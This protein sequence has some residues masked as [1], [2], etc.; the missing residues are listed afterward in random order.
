MKPKS[1]FTGLLLA[2]LITPAWA[3]AP[4]EQTDVVMNA[5]KAA[6]QSAQTTQTEAEKLKVLLTHS[7]PPVVPSLPPPAAI[8]KKWHPGHY[9]EA[10]EEHRNGV[11][12]DSEQIAK[13]PEITGIKMRVYWSHLE[14]TQGTYNFSKIESFLALAKA[15]NK[16]LIIEL[17]DR[18]FAT[19]LTPNTAP[20]PADMLPTW[21]VPFFEFGGGTAR[22]WE[23]PVMD[24]FIALIQEIAKRYDAHPN[25]QG[26]KTPESAF[27]VDLSPAA[28]AKT[29]WSFIKYETQTKRL[30]V[31]ADAAFKRSIFFSGLNWSSYVP[32]LATFIAGTQTGITHPD[33]TNSA[34]IPVYQE[35]IRLK[36]KVPLL[37]NMETGLLH[38]T[39]T[40][41]AILLK[42]VNTLG[43]QFVAWER[44][45]FGKDPI[46]PRHAASKAGT[47][48]K[49]YV[50]PVIRKHPNI[51][52]DIP[53]PSNLTYAR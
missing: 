24:R 31:A 32:A 5:A 20:I 52:R 45:F 9:L 35:E 16:M 34:A 36:G 43:A 30:I 3:L 29:G 26:L 28:V 42:A 18:C 14:P 11:S 13:I 39:D 38:R 51:M 15:H 46:D 44:W 7:P 47:I 2:L 1:M 12:W 49:D 17:W 33:T 37:A 4:L 50:L 21:S 25:F 48:L 53:P 23:A 27:S 19:C 8:S 10:A 6:V 22:I 40:E 41:E